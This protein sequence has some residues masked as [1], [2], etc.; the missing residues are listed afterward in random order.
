M[1]QLADGSSSTSGRDVR[2]A[3]NDPSEAVVRVP[4]SRRFVAPVR[5]LTVALAAQC[6]L[7]VDEIEDLQMAVDEA[8]S[9]L[10]PHAGG[11][12][13]WLQAKFRLL[14]G[15]LAVEAGVPVESSSPNRLDRDGLSWTV[16]TALADRLEISDEGQTLTICLI[17]RRRASQP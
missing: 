15:E 10:L 5:G 6:G 9:L 17:K 12:N 16:L 11:P 14:D 13:P 7:T 4:A 3:S 8:C 2:D 1:N